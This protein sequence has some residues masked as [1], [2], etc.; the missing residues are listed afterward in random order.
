MAQASTTL[1]IKTE[2]VTE[3]YKDI[4]KLLGPLQ[5]INHM[6]YN[7]N[8]ALGISSKESKTYK[9]SLEGASNAGKKA[10]DETKKLQTQLRAAAKSATQ[11]GTSAKAAGAA[12]NFNQIT[13]ALGTVKNAIGSVLNSFMDWSKAS[14]IQA[15]AEGKLANSLQNLN[16]KAN[17]DN[18]KEWAGALQNNT[19][20]GD[21]L[22]LNLANQS[23]AFA[24]SEKDIK[25][26]T[27]AVLNLSAGTGQDAK[28]A[29]QTFNAALAGNVKGLQQA[30]IYFTENEK[31]V[32]KEAKQQ[33][34]LAVLLEKVTEKYG[35]LA[36]VMANTPE[37]ALKQVQNI[38]GDIKEKI[39]DVVSV[40]ITAMLK[41]IGK[42]LANI[43]NLAAQWSKDQEVTDFAIKAAAVAMEAVQKGILVVVTA[44]STVYKS[45]QGWVY[46]IDIAKQGLGYLGKIGAA[47]TGDFSLWEKSENYIVQAQKELNKDL[48]D[49]AENEKKVN[50]VLGKIAEAAGT[51]ETNFDKALNEAKGAAGAKKYITGAQ[52]TFDTNE[53]KAKV[54]LESAEPLDLSNMF[55]GQAFDISSMQMMSEQAL[56]IKQDF[57]AKSLQIEQQFMAQKQALQQMMGLAGDDPQKLQWVKEQQLAIEQNYEQQKHDLK[58]QYAQQT[59]D[60]LTVIQDQYYE[61]IKQK[62]QELANIQAE[63]Q[64]N[65]KQN[66]QGGLTDA[67]T[68]MFEAAVEGQDAFREAAY[69]AM[70]SMAHNVFTNSIS[71]IVKN[72]VAW[73]TGAGES[74]AG[75]PVIGPILAAAASGA[76]LATM[77]IM[78]AKAGKEAKVQYATGGYV[79][80]GIVHGYSNT[81]KDSVSALLQ[82]GERVLSK[83][84]TKAYDNKINQQN[85]NVNIYV[86][87]SGG[88]DKNTIQTEVRQY[89]IPEIKRALKQGY[90]LT[91]A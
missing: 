40:P 83:E 66:L 5:G 63:W 49:T 33:E 61:H 24:K 73:A 1:L 50:E 79:S 36:K 68:S 26:T 35:G 9:Q 23:T 34:K 8:K 31:K 18:L 85:Q 7:L 57:E 38:I 67:F 52:Q 51:M 45:I 6:L 59:G 44:A 58:I 80:A 10:A 86:N 30:G 12:F 29:M 78:K 47:I 64:N 22:I 16:I 46:L 41:T 37:G 39:G 60:Q 88:F 25:K 4:G 69:N 56:K 55:Q 72:I 27:E 70:K 20:F 91:P 77:G 32:F 13:Q 75:I 62:E 74:Q 2:G 53:F 76:V 48:K 81:K 43:D 3:G 21:E 71:T 11:L 84:E 19:T 65:M 17:V 89:L 42:F 87:I 90:T 82:P 14:E 54:A 28:Q 15:E